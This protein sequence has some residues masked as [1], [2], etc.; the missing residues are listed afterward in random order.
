MVGGAQS[1]T[2][3]AGRARGTAASMSAPK[4]PVVCAALRLRVV[5]HNMGHGAC[6]HGSAP[7]P[8]PPMQC[9]AHLP[10]VRTRPA[11]TCLLAEPADS[12]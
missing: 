7:H 10:H 8:L 4:H 1:H 3:P 6:M 5:Q 12:F 2:V 9:C 11:A